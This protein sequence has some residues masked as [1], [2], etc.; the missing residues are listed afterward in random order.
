[1]RSLKLAAVAA[2]AASS[3]VGADAFAQCAF[4]GPSKA[5]GFRTSLVRAFYGC[6][7]TSFPA[8]NSQTGTG[9]PACS[10]PY[11]YSIYG[12]D[13]HGSCTLKLDAK[14]EEPCS[15]GF[16][17]ECTGLTFGV[18]CSGILDPGGA[19]L[20]NAPGFKL[21]M[22]VRTTIDD[23]DNGDMTVI[24]FPIWI[25]VPPAKNGKLSV[26]TR[27]SSPLLD[28]GPGLPGCAELE[29]V[30]ATLRDPDDNP[31]A[32]LGAGTRPKGF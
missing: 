18:K 12:F 20:T 22:V 17:S 13:P 15:T 10:P 19:T 30:H 1:M 11:P 4:D 6:P 2:V 25:A 8:P 16:S 31:F 24:D 9:V 14:R 29:L 21:S 26:S 32:T 3:L 28:L 27:L 7:A 5:K 23:R